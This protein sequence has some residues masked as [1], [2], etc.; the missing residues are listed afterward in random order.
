M[1][2]QL[3]QL[4]ESAEGVTRVLYQAPEQV[5]EGSDESIPGMVTAFAKRGRTALPALINTLDAADIE[6]QSVQ[7]RE[8][9]LE[10][11]FLALT[12]R[13]LRD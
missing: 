1:S 4:Q 10:A 8:P 2:W 12:G 3:Q 13:A 6:I 9:D 5:A 11:V 7:I